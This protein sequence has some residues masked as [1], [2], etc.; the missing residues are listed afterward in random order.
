MP[1]HLS[2]HKLLSLKGLL[3][4]AIVLTLLVSLGAGAYRFAVETTARNR[5][6]VIHS[7]VLNALEVFKSQPQNGDAYPQPA[8]PDET[9]VIDGKTV[10]IGGAM[11]LY[12][13]LTG[14]GTSEIMPGG[15]PAKVSNGRSDDDD[16]ARIL[17]AELQKGEMLV[18]EGRYMLIDA[19]G[20]PLQYV[21]GGKNETVSAT[22][23]LWS[24]GGD[25]ATLGEYRI[26]VRRDPAATAKWV[27]EF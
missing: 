12:Q 23:D 11:M 17:V 9:M 24:Y 1:H 4:F 8:R 27:K 14:D 15:D 10:R 2:E 16:P 5:T 13:L 20:H 18:S 25:L 19:H 22:F 26:E 7:G 3:V 21:P 6:A